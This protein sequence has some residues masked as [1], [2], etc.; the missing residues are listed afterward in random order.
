MPRLRGRHARARARRRRRARRPRPKVCGHPRT[1]TFGLLADY[2]I[3]VVRTEHVASAAEAVA[4][5]RE[6]GFPVALKAAAPE[7]VHKTDV[8]GVRLG[9]TSERAVRRAF[10]EMR[11]ALGPAMGGAIV[12]PMVPPGVELIVG[13]NHDPTFGPLVALR[14]GWLRRRASARYG[15]RRPTAH[16]R[17]HR[18]IAAIAAR[19]TAAVRVPRLRAG[20]RRCA[21]AT[22]SAGSG[23]S[24]RKSTRSPNSTATRSWFRGRRGRRRRQVASGDPPARR[25]APSTSTEGAAPGRGPS[26][27]ARWTRRW[28]SAQRSRDAI[29][30]RA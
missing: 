1:L 25:R 15:A 21:G 19:V 16:R 3:P 18:P 8:G 30:D 10:A 20:R 17:R 23:C 7:L 28:S 22:S 26:P 24:R 27:L 5:A 14:H 6:L 29:G 4:R 11:A 12:Q 9:L 2:G 13:I